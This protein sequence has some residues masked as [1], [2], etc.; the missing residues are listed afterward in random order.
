[1][2]ISFGQFNNVVDA[3]S[4]TFKKDSVVGVDIKFEHDSKTSIMLVKKLLLK[5]K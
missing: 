5:I 2:D 4:I 1:M 3:S